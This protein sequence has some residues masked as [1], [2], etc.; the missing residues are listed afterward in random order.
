LMVQN[1]LDVYQDALQHSKVLVIKL[2]SLGDIILSTAALKAIREKFNRGFAISVLVGEESKDVLLR[3]PYIDELLVADVKNKDR[4]VL[5]LLRL[6]AQLR[7]KDFD[8]VLDLQNNRASH[9]LSRFTLALDRYGYDNKKFGF[10]L[11]HRIKNDVVD[12]DPVTHQFRILKMLGIE[13]KDARLEVW[14]SAQ[15]EAYIEELLSAQW[16]SAHQRLVGINVSASPRWL[17]KNWPPAHVVRL[18]EELTRRDMRIVLTGTERDSMQA[19]QLMSQV[20]SA[21]PINTCGKTTVNQLACLIKRCSVYISTDSAPLHIAASVGTP[22]IALFGPTD[23]KRHLPPAQK[24]SVIK[25]ELP[26][27]PCY[28]TGCKTRNC[29]ELITPEEVADA[30]DTLLGAAPEKS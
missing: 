6:A 19:H 17:T 28:K 9:L 4:G 10:L 30:V 22:F 11:N 24:Y 1:T 15:D 29:M 25:K 2:G 12:L 7:K 27:S 23:Y 5:G 3:C 8:V 14:P 13:L 20:T 21:K 26:C 18:C 16:M